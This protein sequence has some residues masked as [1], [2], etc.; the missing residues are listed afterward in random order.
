M[1]FTANVIFSTLKVEMSEFPRLLPL[2]V[3]IRTVAAGTFVDGKIIFRTLA[4]KLK[5]QSEALNSFTVPLLL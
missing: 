3:S 5:V 4:G 1:T 2:F